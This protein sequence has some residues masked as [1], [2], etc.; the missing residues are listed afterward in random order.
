VA[1]DAVAEV[2]GPG[3]RGGSA[4]GIVGEA[5]EEATDA[6]DGDAEGEGD[7]VEIAGGLA[8][9]DVALDEL[10]GNQAKDEGADDGFATH[11]ICGVVQ[12]LPGEYRVFQ[13]EEKLGAECCS[14]DGGCD[15]GP[16]DG[17]GDGIAEAAAEREIDAEGDEVGESFEEDV[18]V[19]DVA[20]EVE[21]DGEVCGRE[22]ECGDDGE[23]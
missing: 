18:R 6:A 10:D 21:I 4:V 19:D 3:E 14:G 12:V 8:E 22:M 9:S 1:R 5:G 20:A 13:P 15:H 17:R 11:E 2:D 23:L 16:T 7:G